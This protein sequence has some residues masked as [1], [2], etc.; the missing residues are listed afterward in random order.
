MTA[1]HDLHETTWERNGIE[2]VSVL[3]ESND[4]YRKGQLFRHD[5]KK[6]C[7]SDTLEEYFITNF[8]FRVFNFVKACI[9][10]NN[11]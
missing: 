5:V 3:K 8:T 7:K 1:F 2:R 6:H 9:K 11:C 10:P 4:T